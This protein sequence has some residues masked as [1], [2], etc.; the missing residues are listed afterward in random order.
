MLMD[1]ELAAGQRVLEIPIAEL[2]GVS[3]M[4]GQMAFR[5]LE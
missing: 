3:R 2:L 5:I 4:T 1:G